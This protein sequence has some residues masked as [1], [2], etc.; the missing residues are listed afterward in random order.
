M[1]SRKDV[2]KKHFT[3]EQLSWLFRT[4][5]DYKSP[6]S[7]AQAVRDAARLLMAGRQFAGE[8]KEKKTENM[9]KLAKL[10]LGKDTFSLKDAAAKVGFTGKDAEAE[11]RDAYYGN[12]PEKTPKADNTTLAAWYATLNDAYGDNGWNLVKK[13]LQ[14][15]ELERMNKDIATRRKNIMEGYDEEGKEAKV[16]PWAQSALMGLAM[17]RQKQAYIAGRDP[18][19]GEILMDSF[20]NAAY[21]MPVGGIEKAIMSRV[22]QNMA[23]RVA[24][25]VGSNMVAPAAVTVG[26]AA[27]GGKDYANW[28][29]AAIDVALGTA[30]NLGVNK[31]ISTMAA[32]GLGMLQGDVKSAKVTA[33][34]NMLLGKPGER[35]LAL[36]YIDD[37]TERATRVM[38]SKTALDDAAKNQLLDDL[39]VA[40][41]GRMLRSGE[42]GHLGQNILEANKWAKEP[43]TSAGELIGKEPLWQIDL[44][45]AINNRISPERILE[46]KVA[47]RNVLGKTTPPK[48]DDNL[49]TFL[50]DVPGPDDINREVLRNHPELEIAT[51]P[52]DERKE[53]GKKALIAA[54]NYAVNKFGSDRDASRLLQVFPLPYDLNDLRKKQKEWRDEQAK[55][56]KA[57]KQ[58]SRLLKLLD[59]QKWSD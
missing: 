23:G 36:K 33:L 52:V 24:G 28:K 17:P 9:A 2:M 37:A 48:A 3:D 15:S 38:T 12:N 44:E 14:K 1:S 19:T 26:D 8:N 34:Q 47:G 39:R 45:T 40:E 55:Q 21:A 16:L 20:S 27:L 53:L 43:N 29:D 31:G 58:R 42:N 50:A 56:E 32:R 4:Y 41:F 10:V 7:D 22:G 51:L 35:E 59:L 25:A 13:E 57:D 18:T 5:P 46:A 49:A 6:E 54:K 11:F 30:T